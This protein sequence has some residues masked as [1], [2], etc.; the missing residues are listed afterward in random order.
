MKLKSSIQTCKENLPFDEKMGF[1]Y[2]DAL[3]GHALSQA[4][5]DESIEITKRIKQRAKKYMK[6]WQK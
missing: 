5:K 4:I 6:D 1:P 3:V 2:H